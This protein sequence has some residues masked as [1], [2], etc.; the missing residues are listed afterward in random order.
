[1][2]SCKSVV[3]VANKVNHKARFDTKEVY[4][5]TVTKR[6]QYQKDKVI[7]LDDSLFN[8]LI[9]DVIS[10]R[11]STYYGIVNKNHFVSADQLNIKSCSGQIEVLYRLCKEDSEELKKKKQKPL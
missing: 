6:N 7:I 2:V 4:L 11:L 5:Q 1:M 8:S 9:N 3:A 10:K